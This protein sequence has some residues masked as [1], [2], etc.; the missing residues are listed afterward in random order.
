MNL[1]EG[2]LSAALDDVRLGSQ[3]ISL[4]ADVAVKRPGLSKYA[5]RTVVVGIRPEDLPAVSGE[6]HGSSLAGDVLLV[7]ALGAEILVHF[8]IDA[9]IVQLDDTQ[10]AADGEKLQA[11]SVSVE[12]EC[13]ARIEPRNVVHA[14]ERFTFDVLPDRLE[15]FDFDTGLSIW[16]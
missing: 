12:S 11:N 1:L 14:G 7:E 4:P 15:F 2:T 3:H 13:V 8:R 9:P 10:S 5:G 16:E 6:S